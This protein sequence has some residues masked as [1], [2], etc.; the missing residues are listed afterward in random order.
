MVY[1]LIV[2][3]LSSWSQKGKSPHT[4]KGWRPITLPNADYKIVSTVISNRL[5]SV[6]SKIINPAQTA[7]KSGRYIGENTRLVHDIIHWTKNNNKKGIILAADFEA[8]FESVA[9]N[10]LRLVIH[11]LN[12]GPN[13]KK[14]IDYLYLNSKNHYR[15]LVNSHLGNTIFLRRGIRQCDLGS[16]YLFNLAVSILTEQIIK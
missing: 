12:F 13:L 6:M 15:V 8:A 2:R 10:Y 4:Y 9:W 3:A 7:Y 11:K 14:M 1:L 16:G 5:K